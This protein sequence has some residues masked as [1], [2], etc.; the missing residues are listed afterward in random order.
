MN[1]HC[2]VQEDENGDAYIVFPDEMIKDLG[3]AVGDTLEWS[4]ED[5]RCIL[6]KRQDDSSNEA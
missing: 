6:R 1:Y 5:G 2:V 4:I 3:W